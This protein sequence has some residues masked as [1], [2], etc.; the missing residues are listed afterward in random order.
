[1]KKKKFVRKYV[2]QEIL[3]GK[4]KLEEHYAKA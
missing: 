2:K 4:I 3:K 1:M